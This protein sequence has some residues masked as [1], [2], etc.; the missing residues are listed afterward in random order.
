MN[1]SDKS[2]QRQPIAL[3]DRVSDLPSGYIGIVTKKAETLGGSIEC[4][5]QRPAL[6]D[7]TVPVAEWFA[8]G[9][10]RLIDSPP[11]GAKIEQAMV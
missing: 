9:R 6:D 5:V 2:E 7:G 8:I 11:V 3:G 10:L 4:E 1:D